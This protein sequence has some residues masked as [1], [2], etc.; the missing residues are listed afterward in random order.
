[1][2][3]AKTLLEEEALEEATDQT[4]FNEINSKKGRK[5]NIKLFF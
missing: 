3:A 1:M 4:K 5:V 2:F